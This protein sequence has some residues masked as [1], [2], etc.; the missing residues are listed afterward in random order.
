ME[1]KF[2]PKPAED[3]PTLLKQFQALIRL[4]SSQADYVVS[5]RNEVIGLLSQIGLLGPG[6]AESQRDA[7]AE[8]TTLLEQQE[9]ELARL[10]NDLDQ[11]SIERNA[12]RE[13]LLIK[14][15]TGETAYRAAADIYYQLVQECDIPE[16][17]SL[18]TYVDTLRDAADNMVKA[19]TGEIGM[20]RKQAVTELVEALDASNQ[21][22]GDNEIM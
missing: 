2:N 11:T 12:L 10:R 19:M 4:H 21:G 13:E 16:G 5:L 7:N 3:Y 15:G 8:L 17:G 14:P 22:K 1:P 20:S 6:E 18:V 9:I